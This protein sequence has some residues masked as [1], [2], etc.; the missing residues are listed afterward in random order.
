MRTL[1]TLVLSI[2]I[3]LC[4]ATAHAAPLHIVLYPDSAQ[5]TDTVRV[6]LEAA[7]GGVAGAFT[8]PLAVDPSSIGLAVDSPAKLTLTDVSIDRRPMRDEAAIAE[9]R[10]RL[11]T[12]RD[13]RQ[14]LIDTR[15]AFEAAANFWRSQ[16]LT[17]SVTPS[18]V[19]A[20]AAAVRDGVASSLTAVSNLVP[21]IAD[22][23]RLIAE[24][25]AELERL[26]GGAADTWRVTAHFADATA[27][28]AT[29]TVSYR[30]TQCGWTSR[31]TLNA[32]PSEGRV[33]VA[34][35]A[36]IH[37]N[38]G[39]NWTDAQVVLSTG[40]S[41]GRTEPPAVRP[42]VVG[43]IKPVLL[44][45]AAM[46]NAPTEMAMMAAAPAPEQIH[47]REGIFFDE[48]DAGRVSLESGANRRVALRR[49]TWNATFDYLVR[50]QESDSAF[51]HATVN[52][53]ATPRLPR[54]EATFLLDSAFIRKSVF[55]LSGREADLHFGADPQLRVKL[56]T[57]DKKSGS[58]GIISKKNTYD[59]DWRLTVTNGKKVPAALRVE[60]ALPSLRDERIKM[61]KRLPGATEAEGVATWTDTIAPGAEKTIEYGYSLSWPSDMHLDLGGR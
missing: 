31:Y 24:M 46:D 26:T 23:D 40:R 7:P 36:E 58:G 47:M 17:R 57:L 48:Y 61:E 27:R 8:L 30:L 18:N 28:E 51:V 60:D 2:G 59:W 54:G 12:E 20:M 49:L 21:R 9:L 50:P 55:A 32:L 35:D 41:A 13:A 4:A 15:S 16:E 14:N 10:K 34:W 44:R 6:P 11:N 5:V 42:W 33:D 29:L 22:K 53:D 39:M 45:K 25:E 19:H 43:P 52:L 38:T 3:L 37:Q 1:S 56:E